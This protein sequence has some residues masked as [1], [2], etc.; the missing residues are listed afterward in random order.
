MKRSR[1]ERRVDAA[2]QLK[3]HTFKNSRAKRTGSA[4]QEEWEASKDA[5]LAHL[6][7]LIHGRKA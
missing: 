5:K 4:T 7:D 3:L 1:H 6:E 2:A